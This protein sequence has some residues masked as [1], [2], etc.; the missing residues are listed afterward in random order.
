V[1]KAV[2]RLGLILLGLV[3]LGLCGCASW[4][5]SLIYVPSQDSPARLDALAKAHGIERWKNT[6][7]EN[8]GWRWPARQRPARGQLLVTHGNAGY[9]LQRSYLANPLSEAGA[10]DVFVLEYPGYGDRPGPPTEK[11]L[12]KAAEEAIEE[13]PRTR[14]LTSSASLWAQASPRTSQASI[15]SPCRVC[16]CLRPIIPWSGVAQYHMKVLPAWLILCDRFRSEKYLANYNGPSGFSSVTR[17]QIVPA[18]FG[19]KLFDSYKGPKQLW[20]FPDGD[21]GSINRN[22]RN[23]GMAWWRSGARMRSES[24]YGVSTKKSGAKAPLLASA[25]PQESFEYLRSLSPCREKSNR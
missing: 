22:R 4:Q 13:L 8:I 3:S 5:R 1:G 24:E 7:G 14:Q 15:Q 25:L 12:F 6:A 17:T 10:L 9:A 23:S 11:A 2:R 18:K 20:E 16:C 19:R 21:H